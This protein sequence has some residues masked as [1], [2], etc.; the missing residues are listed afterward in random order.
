MML[1]QISIG[2]MTQHGLE[3][4]CSV[5]NIRSSNLGMSSKLPNAMSIEFFWSEG[6]Y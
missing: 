5:D 3:G 2:L 1:E 6:I 4:I